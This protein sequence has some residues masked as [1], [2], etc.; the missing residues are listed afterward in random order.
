MEYPN[1]LINTVKL[2]DETGREVTF[3]HLLTFDYEGR[4]IIALMP[5]EEAEGIGEG[6][7]LLLCIEQDENGKDVYVPID[8]EILL[9]EAFDR[10]LELMDELDEAEDE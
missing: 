4:R 7:V 1:E 2:T 6:E 10:F 9:N 8:N 5:M 3:D